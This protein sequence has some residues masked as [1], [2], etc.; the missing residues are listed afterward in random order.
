M[1]ANHDDANSVPAAAPRADGSA[2]DGRPTVFGRQSTWLRVAVRLV[3]WPALVSVIV[4]LQF[5]RFR[6]ATVE[7]QAISVIRLVVGCVFVVASIACYSGLTRATLVNPADR[8]PRALM[9]RIQLSTRALANVVPGGNATAS[10]LGYRLLTQS[11]VSTS[12]AGFALATAGLGSAVVLNVL[13]WVALAYS[14]PT[15]GTDRAFLIVA[16]VGLILVAAAAIVTYALTRD[17]E[18]VPRP[19]RRLAVRLS[20]DPERVAALPREIRHR[21]AALRDDRGL[22]GRLVGWSIGQWTLDMAALWVFLS[23]FDIRLDPLVLILVFGA[24]NIAAAVPVTPGGLGVVEAV[25]ITSLVQIGFTFQAATFGVAAYRLAHYVFPIIAGGVSYLTLRAGPWKL[26][27]VTK[28]SEPSHSNRQDDL[29]ETDPPANPGAFTRVQLVG[30]TTRPL[31]RFGS[32]P[33][34]LLWNMTSR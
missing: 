16:A 8:I 24:A 22:V 33:E 3:L 21:F 14:L 26:T 31:P 20:I 28:P 34:E 13:F 4:I 17:I 30:W 23:A 11:G 5:P 12:G 19:V 1:N 29:G 15:Q 32:H 27:P 9:Y 18:R 25:Y 6:D 7:L 2:V 10:A